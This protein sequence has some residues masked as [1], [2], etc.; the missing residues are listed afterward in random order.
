[1][2][3]NLK[4]FPNCYLFP[5]PSI[6][7]QILPSITMTN[8]ISGCETMQYCHYNAGFRVLIKRLS[9]ILLFSFHE[10]VR[11]RAFS[12]ERCKHLNYF[13]WWWI[14]KKY[15]LLSNNVFQ[16]H[17]IFIRYSTK[18]TKTV[19]SGNA[20]KKFRLGKKLFVT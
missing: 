20:A 7:F 2:Y 3:I 13:A 11:N 9:Y 4:G 18:I 12:K 10:N 8:K 15:C 14:Y 19:L 1:M 17:E 16:Q 5:F 6:I